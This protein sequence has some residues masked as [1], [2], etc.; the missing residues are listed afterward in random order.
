MSL[1]LLPQQEFL[2]ALDKSDSIISDE[3]HMSI[4]HTILYFFPIK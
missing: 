4:S 1:H 3:K 2:S